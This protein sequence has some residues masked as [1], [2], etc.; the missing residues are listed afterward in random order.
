MMFGSL[1]G[2]ARYLERGRHWRCQE[3]QLP[4]H[5]EGRTFLSGQFYFFRNPALLRAH[6][7]EFPLSASW[8]SSL[9]PGNRGAHGEDG[10]RS[11]PLP[12]CPSR[13]LPLSFS[14]LHES[15]K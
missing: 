12:T 7:C 8:E 1:G 2:E 9:C 11:P 10:Q 14:V 4:G 6:W 5:E 13:V 15:F 3:R